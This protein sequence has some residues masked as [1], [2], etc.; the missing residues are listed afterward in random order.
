MLNGLARHEKQFIVPCLGRRPGTK[1][2]AARH[3]R[4]VGPWRPVQ[5]RAVPARGRAG[6]GRAGPLAIYTCTPAVTRVRQ[7]NHSYGPDEANQHQLRYRSRST[8]RAVL[9]LPAC[10]SFSLAS[11][12]M[13]CQAPTTRAPRLAASRPG[14]RWLARPVVAGR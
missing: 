6:P 11:R 9:T 12:G 1:P 5:D 3:G 13:P 7:A 14:S 2:V 10:F 4:P 8:Q